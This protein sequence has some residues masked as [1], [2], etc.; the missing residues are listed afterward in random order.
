MYFGLSALF[1]W[2]LHAEVNIKWYY[3]VILFAICWGILM[4][5]FQNLMHLGRS[6]EYFDILS[7]SIG[8]LIG[9]FLYIFLVRLKIN[10]DLR[11]S[12]NLNEF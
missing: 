7:N 1:C 11:K 6:F 10:I 4:E 8:A 5:V 3:I 2:L 9:V 12:S